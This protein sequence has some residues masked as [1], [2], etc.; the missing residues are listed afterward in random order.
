MKALETIKIQKTNYSIYC[1]KHGGYN[2]VRLGR[3]I[4]FDSLVA[5]HSFINA[6]LAKSL[7]L[8]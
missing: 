2:V 7:N 1:S 3:L 4:H 6:K 8:K 5:A